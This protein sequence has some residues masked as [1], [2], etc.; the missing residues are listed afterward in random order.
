MPARGRN[1][2]T[3]HFGTSRNRKGSGRRSSQRSPE[4]QPPLKRLP[5][6]GRSSGR[7]RAFAGFSA[8]ASPTLSSIA[9][10]LMPWSFSRSPIPS[11]GRATGVPGGSRKSR[12][13]TRCTRPAHSL[14]PLGRDLAG[15]RGYVSQTADGGIASDPRPSRC[16]QVVLHVIP[17]VACR[18]TGLCSTR[19]CS[20]R[21][22][23]RDA[24]PR[25]RCWNWLGPVS[26]RE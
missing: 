17:S 21:H 19:T 5:P 10:I 1:S 12:L 24:G 7:V 16:L 23:A 2:R 13:T 22:Y 3:P 8:R 9:A 18:S 20:S 6:L 11:A 15:E 25:S 26:S 14:A 4:R